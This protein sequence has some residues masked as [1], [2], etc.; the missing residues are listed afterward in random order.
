MNI[1]TSELTA[2]EFSAYGN[3]VVLN[4]IDCNKTGAFTFYPDQVIGLFG[5]NSLAGFGVC[6]INKR[7]MIVETVEMHE[8]TE[9]VV[10]LAGCDSIMLVGERSGLTPD[11]SKFKAFLMP[12]DCLVRIKKHIWHSVPFPVEDIRMMAIAVLPPYT[13]ANDSV[14]IN[15]AEPIEIE[16]SA[17][18]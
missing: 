17:S 6:G 2:P 10:F 11:L 15:L 13:Y 18:A 1:K 12:K 16:D 4:E 5:S 3:Y 14:V 9:E 7:A 8:N